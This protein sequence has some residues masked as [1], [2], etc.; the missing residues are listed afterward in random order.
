MTAPRPTHTCP[1]CKSVQV[2]RHKLACRP[3]WYRL[4][5]ALRQRINDAYRRDS[6]AHRGALREA[7]DWYRDHPAVTS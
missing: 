4:P 7:F 2:P 1:G 5:R 3:C 6:A